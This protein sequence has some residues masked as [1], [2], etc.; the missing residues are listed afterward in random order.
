MSL[1]AFLRWMTC[2]LSVRD[3]FTEQWHKGQQLGTKWRLVQWFDLSVHWCE[4][5]DW[6][7]GASMWWRTGGNGKVGW[8]CSAD[9]GKG[10]MFRW[11]YSMLGAG[12]CI[13]NT[14]LERWYNIFILA[15]SEL[16]GFWQYTM[17]TS[18]ALYYCGVHCRSN[19]QNLPTCGLAFSCGMQTACWLHCLS[20][21]SFVFVPQSNHWHVLVR[22][23]V[24]MRGLHA[25]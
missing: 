15:T 7:G 6:G 5:F 2:C 22:A 8:P 9:M 14:L 4:N 16:T 25:R 17:H 1:V 18:Y 19:L 20:W 10:A 21:D 3:Q 24:W 11:K 23:L 12:Q 13:A